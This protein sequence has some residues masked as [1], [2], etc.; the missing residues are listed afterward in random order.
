M[1]RRNELGGNPLGPKVLVHSRAGFS[2]HSALP[3]QTGDPRI[4]RGGLS[5]CVHRAGPKRGGNELSPRENAAEIQQKSGFSWG[6]R[7]PG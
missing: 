3:R 4:L 7:L 6:W 5:G 2:Q 1:V